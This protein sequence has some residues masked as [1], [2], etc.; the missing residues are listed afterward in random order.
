MAE[1]EQKEQGSSPFS[2]VDLVHIIA[3]GA[4]CGRCRT[5]LVS[6]SFALLQVSQGGCS[7]GR[8][9]PSHISRFTVPEQPPSRRVSNVDESRT[10]G[11]SCGMKENM[12]SALGPCDGIVRWSHTCGRHQSKKSEFSS[13][14][15]CKAWLTPNL[16]DGSEDLVT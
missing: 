15:T 8:T 1:N 3:Q 10:R 6:V 9:N 4:N 14:C 7:A 2:V 5:C 16:V 13:R 12:S 11:N